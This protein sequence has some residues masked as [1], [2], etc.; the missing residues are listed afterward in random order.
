MFGSLAMCCYSSCS[1][2]PVL[3]KAL[4]LRKENRRISFPWVS[5]SLSFGSL[6]AIKI[7][8]KSHV[9]SNLTSAG[10]PTLAASSCHNVP[11]S[12]YLRRKAIMRERVLRKELMAC[13]YDFDGSPESMT[14]PPYA[15]GLDH[16]FSTGELKPSPP[17]IGKNGVRAPVLPRP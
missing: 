9:A 12:P 8:V 2:R 11:V 6:E 7:E 3:Q 4:D 13:S 15:C 1:A 17:R 16:P 5:I 10:F 14:S